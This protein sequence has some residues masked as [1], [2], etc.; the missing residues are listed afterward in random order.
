MNTFAFRDRVDAVYYG[1]TESHALAVG[2]LR[3][4]PFA[5][6]F[7]LEVD[8]AS[9]KPVDGKSR[10]TKTKSTR[11][12]EDVI[13]IGHQAWV[14][15]GSPGSRW[16]T[17]TFR[18]S[19]AAAPGADPLNFALGIAGA[20]LRSVSTVGVARRRGA[21]AWVVRGLYPISVGAGPGRPVNEVV[22]YEILQ[23]NYALEATTVR[24]DDR[25]DRTHTLARVDLSRFGAPVTIVK[26]RV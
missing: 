21:R 6:S 8:N 7:H 11:V 16:R 13:E 22:T 17:T 2:V 26:P 20:A 25:I 1:L 12:A 4:R 23:R 3:A 18:G 24:L 14:K 9:I 5:I 15:P 19:V 10:R